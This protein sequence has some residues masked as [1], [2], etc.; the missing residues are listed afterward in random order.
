MDQEKRIREINAIVDNMT[1]VTN[2]TSLET[3]KSYTMD[4]IKQIMT[5]L[6]TDDKFYVLWNW[7][8]NDNFVADVKW[9]PIVNEFAKEFTV[10]VTLLKDNNNFIIQYSKEKA[11]QMQDVILEMMYLTNDYSNDNLK[12]SMD[13]T[14]NIIGE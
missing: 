13:I 7:G 8:K 4:D 14:N 3:F 9:K 2:L 5:S 11:K 10:L 6:Q 12:K 1:K